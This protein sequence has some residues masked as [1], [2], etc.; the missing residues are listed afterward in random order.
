MHAQSSK[1]NGL[2]WDDGHIPYDQLH[3]MLNEITAP[4]NHLY[5][6]GSEKCDILNLQLK[7]PIHDYK[8]LNCPDPN[9]L[10]SDFRCYL[11]CHSFPHMRCP[12]RNSRALH[13]WLLYFF[14]N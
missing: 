3:G 4:F 7:G 12:T 11:T 14:K 8:A 10:K 13:N 5:A 6:Y 1:E 2:N 9:D